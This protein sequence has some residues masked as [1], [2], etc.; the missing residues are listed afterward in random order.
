[1]IRRLHVPS[2]MCCLIISR[3]QYHDA[4]RH[5]TVKW[6]RQQSLLERISHISRDLFQ[7]CLSYDMYARMQ[8][9]ELRIRVGGLKLSE[10]P[11]STE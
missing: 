7:T 6:L 10:A 3:V 8:L 5:K 4:D 2:T 1:M 9:A 11:D